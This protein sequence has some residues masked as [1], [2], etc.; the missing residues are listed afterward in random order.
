MTSSEISVIPGKT[1]NSPNHQ[2][3]G[4]R[5]SLGRG[6][7]V[8]LICGASYQDLTAIRN[9]ALVYTLAGV[10]CID[11][12]ADPAV[13]RVAQ[14]GIRV[15]LSLNHA[16]GYADHK[17][18]KFDYPTQSPWLMVSLNDGEDPHFRK[19]QFDP[20]RCPPDCPR[21]C[22]LVCPAWAIAS[23]ADEVAPTGV[24]AEKCYGCGRCLPIC[25][26]E[27]ISTYSHQV[28]VDSL[29]P[30]LESGQIAAL[31][32]HTQVGHGEQF[33][34][35]WHNLQPILPQLKAIAIS[36]PY[37]AQAVEYLQTISGWLGPLAM[38]II[39]Q[40]DG[41]PMSG[42][43]GRGTTH[44]C[45][46]YAD[47]VLQSSLSGFVQLAGGTNGHTITKLSSQGFSVHQPK[48]MVNGVAF[49]S[50]AR[51]LIAPV[52]QAAEA[53]QHNPLAP[54]HLE[55]YPDLLQQ[56][57]ALA[58]SLVQPWKERWTFSEKISEDID[59]NLH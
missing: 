47:Q 16:S 4:P 39:W 31:E 6:C 48:R 55:D 57:I 2:Y 12:A 46:H 53:R 50:C 25:P 34:K 7:W 52:L 3:Q 24:W 49:G 40:T 23:D 58:Q 18:K 9:L 13:V 54:L 15:A 45:L 11:L 20:Q 41:R 38:P 42:D 21:P 43:I 8:K 28:M 44:L 29:L 17:V 27:I 56:A 19:A 10:D 30:W 36:C 26:Q 51:T 14:E 59:N 22:A 1:D 35:L 33:Q 32:I 5:Q 37:H